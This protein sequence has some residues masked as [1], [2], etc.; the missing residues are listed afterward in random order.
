MKR[1]VEPPSSSSLTATPFLSSFFS[2]LLIFDQIFHKICM[3]AHERRTLGTPN[4]KLPG[5]VISRLP[6]R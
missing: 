6:G 3:V 5:I 4:P 2:I 1:T